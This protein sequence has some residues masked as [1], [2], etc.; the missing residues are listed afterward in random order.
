MNFALEMPALTGNPITE[1]HANYCRENGHATHTRDG[2]ED[3]MCPRCGEIKET[4]KTENC[5]VCA[6]AFSYTGICTGVCKECE[7]DPFETDS[8]A[9]RGNRW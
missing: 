2:V 1:R 4:V 7:T 9:G 3:T 6:K 8:Q 5:V